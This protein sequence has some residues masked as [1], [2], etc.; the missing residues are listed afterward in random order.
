MT[1][2]PI[3]GLPMPLVTA[4]P[5]APESLRGVAAGMML[6]LMQ[7]VHA[8]H[9]HTIRPAP[10]YRNRITSDA[11]VLCAIALKHQTSDAIGR[12]KTPAYIQVTVNWADGVS[13]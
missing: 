12:R 9:A 8:R 6:G 5:M 11:T 13:T 4:P 1:V 3:C 2:A 7:Q 10:R